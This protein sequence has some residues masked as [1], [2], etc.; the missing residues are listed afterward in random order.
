M[1]REAMVARKPGHQ[2][3]RAI[4]RKTIARGMPGDSGVTVVTNACAFYTAH[5]AAGAPSAR[6]SLRPLMSEGGIFQEKLARKRRD[7]EIVPVNDAALPRRAWRERV[8]SPSRINPLLTINRAK[9]AQ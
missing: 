3:E 5:A 2:G 4:S 1:I 8:Q 7:R 6:H 9:I